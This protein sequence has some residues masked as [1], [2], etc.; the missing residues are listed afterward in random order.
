MLT[1]DALRTGLEELA[2]RADAGDDVLPEVRRLARLH[3]AVRVSGAGLVV[4]LI[5]VTATAALTRWPGHHDAGPTTGSSES[6]SPNVSYVS[7]ATGPVSVLNAKTYQGSAGSRTWTLTAGAVS[8][9]GAVSW[10]FAADPAAA[11]GGF[12]CGDINFRGGWFENVCDAG[13]AD[14]FDFVGSVVSPDVD[15]IIVTLWSGQ[16]VRVEPLP[17]DAR[18]V[19]VWAFAFPDVDHARDVQA[20]G[21]DGQ[22]LA[23]TDQYPISWKKWLEEDMQ[24]TCDNHDDVPLYEPYCADQYPSP[25]SAG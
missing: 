4:V 22:Q 19:R 11:E 25:I 16:Q 23:G 21:S 1:E 13:A 15:H 17:A 20:Y 24:G 18:G 14:D 9:K 10:T 8:A 3:R 5:A 2:Q 6:V 7:G 12:G